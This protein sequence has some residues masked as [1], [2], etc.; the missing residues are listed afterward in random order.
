M[1]AAYGEEVGKVM[2]F[3]TDLYGLPP[4]RDLAVVETD[5]DAPNGYSAPGIVFLSSKGIGKRPNVRLI[6]NQV[7]RQWWGT[8]VS[9]VT[10]NHIWIS[11]GLAGKRSPRYLHRGAD[12]GES[13][14]RT[15]RAPG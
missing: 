2:A 1:T 11:N 9:P 13:A 8:L 3:L 6:A 12:G 5:N 10:R 7:A 15:G 4:Q 14:G